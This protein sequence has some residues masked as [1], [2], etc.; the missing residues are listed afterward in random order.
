MFDD[1]CRTSVDKMTRVSSTISSFRIIWGS[2]KVAVE[3]GLNGRL[4]PAQLLMAGSRNGLA[5]RRVLDEAL[6]FFTGEHL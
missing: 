4:I 2:G 6:V 3:L 1:G 5:H